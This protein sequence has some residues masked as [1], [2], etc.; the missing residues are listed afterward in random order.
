MSLRVPD[1][2]AEHGMMSLGQLADAAGARRDRL[3]QVM[4]LLHSNGIFEGDPGTGMYKNN[5]R[6]ELLRSDHWTQWH[7]WVELYGNQ[8]Y[9]IARGIPASVREDTTRSAAQHNYN[10]DED[11]FT[12]F[13]KQ[14]WVPLLHRTLGG[15]AVAQAPGIVADY[16]WHELGDKILLDVGGGGG[17]LVAALLRGNSSLRAGI[18]DLPAV[19]EH[20]RPFFLDG[21]QYADIAGRVAQ[22]NLVGGDFFVNVPSHEAYVMKW[23][24][25]DWLDPDA[26]KILKN[27]R[28]AIVPGE[29]SRLIVLESIMT[30]GE[31]GRL[32]RYG[33]INMMM[34]AKGLERTMYD[35]YQLARDSGWKISK[36]HKLRN[37][38]VSAIDMRPE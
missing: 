2:L 26:I 5:F 9:D 38:W 7:N 19:I 18:F 20:T 6:S 12:Y 28:Q 13:Q 15:G 30:G 35:W 36:V 10:T 11:M 33:D 14:G 1:L 4:R 3:G 37:A 21:G 25:H 22:D 16:P 8:F 27:I 23:C 31:M 32:S 34:T 17:G 29:G 24:L